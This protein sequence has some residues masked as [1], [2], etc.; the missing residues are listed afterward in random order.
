[1]YVERLLHFRNRHVAGVRVI[2]FHLALRPG[3]LDRDPLGWRDV[4]DRAYLLADFDLPVKLAED[5]F[6]GGDGDLK[7]L[8]CF[9]VPF[10]S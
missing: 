7:N 8:E 9:I 3:I 6:D 10:D 1:M 5:G 4:I 2:D